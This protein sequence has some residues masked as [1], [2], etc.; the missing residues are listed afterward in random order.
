MVK[1]S[2]FI[3]ISMI[4]LMFLF[5]AD[6]G[7]RV[8]FSPINVKAAGKVQYKVVYF[9]SNTNSADQHYAKYEEFLNS[10]AN[11]G[12]ILDGTTNDVVLR[13]KK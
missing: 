1:E 4:V 10:M 11:E 13:F 6:I 5:C 7:Y 8:I 3:K 9:R 2:S 12:W